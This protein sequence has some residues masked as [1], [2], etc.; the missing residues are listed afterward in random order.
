MEARLSTRWKNEP[1]IR[2]KSFGANSVNVEIDIS[3]QARH[4][5]SACMY[6]CIFTGCRKQV[7]YFMK[8]ALLSRE[9]CGRSEEK[10]GGDGN[11]RL[12]QSD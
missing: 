12:K 9:R 2:C 3:G 8:E 6:V 7:Q 5:R 11:L 1:E 10:E 4:G